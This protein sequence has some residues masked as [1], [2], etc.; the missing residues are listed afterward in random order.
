[1]HYYPKKI[2]VEQLTNGML[3]ILLHITKIGLK[4]LIKLRPHQSSPQINYIKI[5]PSFF[6]IFLSISA[7]LIYLPFSFAWIKKTQL[8]FYQVK[9]EQNADAK[10]FDENMLLVLVIITY[11]FK[12]YRKWMYAGCGW[13]CFLPHSIQKTLKSLIWI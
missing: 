4:S 10:V 8:T 13:G 6:R 12:T 5:G 9:W 7:L 2:F 1:M 11:I 3:L